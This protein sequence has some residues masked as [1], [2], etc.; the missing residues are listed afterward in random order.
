M[1]DHLNRTIKPQAKAAV[2]GS[3][4]CQLDPERAC[5]SD[6]KPTGSCRLRPQA[7]NR[8]SHDHV[9]LAL[10]SPGTGMA[11]KQADADYFDT[12]TRSFMPPCERAARA[13]DD[14]RRNR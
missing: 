7:I 6:R 11:V 9:E 14:A 8:P 12:A 13:P 4:P 2:R 5:S 3:S 10:G 1:G